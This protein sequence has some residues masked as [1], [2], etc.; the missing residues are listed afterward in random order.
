M[1]ELQALKTEI[2]NLKRDINC[3]KN[4]DCCTG[5]NSSN[6]IYSANGTIGANRT[7]NLTDNL[8]FRNT[9]G[10]VNLHQLNSAGGAF[11]AIPTTGV[12]GIGLSSANAKLH[13]K[14]KEATDAGNIF[15]AQ[16][17]SNLE[18]LSLRSDGRLRSFNTVADGVGQTLHSTNAAYT[19]LQ[20]SNTTSSNIQTVYG[21]T[22]SVTKNTNA[23]ERESYIGAKAATDYSGARRSIGFLGETNSTL[24]N[25]GVL[26]NI[27]GSSYGAG[28]KGVAG[29]KSASPGVAIAVGGYFTA[30]I[31][32]DFTSSSNNYAGVIGE[33]I[34][35]GGTANLFGGIFRTVDVSPSVNANLKHVA[36]LVPAS[37]NSG[38]V[39][40]GADARSNNNRAMLEVTGEV[41]LFGNGNGIILKDSVNGNAYRVRITNGNIAVA[42]A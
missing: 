1:F 10:N 21:A 34:A 9:A 15:L 7:A 42:A 29:P 12:V 16:N 17:S 33:A 30:G 13:I 37:N 35:R 18:V 40:L 2:A 6:N 20:V 19:G 41:E 4:G 25:V 31:R 38:I 39:V 5:A 28:V 26:D 8:T 11:L 32:T 22:F 23:N 36:I 14:S 3:I 27:S 24:I